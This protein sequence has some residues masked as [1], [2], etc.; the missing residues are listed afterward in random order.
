MRKY[1]IFILIIVILSTMFGGCKP[2]GNTGFGSEISTEL[3]IIDHG[4][5]VFEEWC[6]SCHNFKQDGI[7]PNLSGLTRS[8]ETNWIKDF[9]KSPQMKMALNDPRAVALK[10]KYKAVMPDFQHLQDADIEAVLAYINT[11]DKIQVDEETDP[12]LVE[13]PIPEKI[14]FSGET[15]NLEYI[16]Q[17]PASD[18]ILPYTRINKLACEKNFGRLFINDLRG[19]LFE[20]RQGKPH[21]YLELNKLRP[22]FIDRNGL[23]TGFASFA[24]H[25]EFDKNGLFYT[26]HNEIAG[27]Q[28]ADFKLPDSIKVNMQGVLTE[29]KA[30]DPSSLSFSGISRELIRFDLIANSHG[31]QELAF[32]PFADK[33]D[34]DYGNLYISIGDGGS[35]QVGYPE[36]VDHHGTDVWGSILR[37]D[38][39]GDNSANNK[40]GIPG[41]NP[42]A[43][44][45]GMQKELWAYGFRNPNRITWI[46]SNRILASDIGQANIEELNIV[47]AGNFYG[48]PIREGRF[49]FDP[50][51]NLNSIY[52][53]PDNDY[54]ST[55][56][57]PI[58]QYDHDEGPAIS[59]GFIAKGKLFE[60]KYIFGDIPTGRLFVSD[61]KNSDYAKVKELK[62]VINGKET[63]FYELTK[64]SRVDLKF[65]R[66]CDDSIYIFTKADGKIYRLIE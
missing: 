65:G 1:P 52:G 34:V 31:L 42:F 35:V 32:N 63:T 21:V 62:I 20:L 28:Q 9:I 12:T 15:A 55:I 22:N 49:L 47:E 10:E 27:S 2:K 24:F 3:K 44:A 46:D 19:V 64:S 14:I 58:V 38:P 6:S 43:N 37:I 40:Y 66:G 45:A 18:T 25:P 30:K 56:T 57:Y 36:I 33:G 5:I 4:K 16:G 7:G 29:W 26:T 59:G 48:W 51:G 17:I 8:V 41:D 60:G 54:E 23:A 13:N 11:Y 39:L 50:K 53:L 61:L